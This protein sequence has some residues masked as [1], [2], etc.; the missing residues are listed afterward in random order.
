V[1]AGVIRALTD[2]NVRMTRSFMLNYFRMRRDH[3]LPSVSPARWLQAHV[4]YSQT[5][6]G[7]F[8]TGCD[9]PFEWIG[10]HMQM[11]INLLFRKEQP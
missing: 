1:A 11:H 9:L 6:D 8:S 2:V 10:I 4:C 5:P 7:A 3:S